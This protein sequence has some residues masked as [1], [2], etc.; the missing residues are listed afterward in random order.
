MCRQRHN[1]SQE[2]SPF[3]SCPLNGA[4]AVL[5][6]CHRHLPLLCIIAKTRCDDG[7][8]P[9]GESAP[10]GPCTLA[11]SDP[12]LCG[13]ARGHSSAS[14]SR[15]GTVDPA[16]SNGLSAVR[17]QARYRALRPLQTHQILLPPAVD[18]VVVQALMM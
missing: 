18:S 7:T 12:A 4:S 16:R 15:R 13:I 11:C 1:R 3:L 8:P 14:G 2:G 17:R 6:T 9:L 10:G 5:L